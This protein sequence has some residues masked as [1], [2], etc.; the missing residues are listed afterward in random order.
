[1][2]KHK[3]TEPRGEVMRNAE[4]T[5]QI[6]RYWHLADRP[7]PHKPPK[8]YNYVKELTHLQIE[9]IKMQEWVKQAA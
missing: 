9:L 4:E 7:V 2:A 5:A 6:E 3:V 1:M 8:D